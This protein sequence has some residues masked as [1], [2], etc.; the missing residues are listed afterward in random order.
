MK[1]HLLFLCIRVEVES[2]IISLSKTIQEFEQQTAYIF[3]DTENVT[4]LDSEILQTETFNPF[5][6]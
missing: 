5:S 1:K 2:N 4:V 3:G 6:N